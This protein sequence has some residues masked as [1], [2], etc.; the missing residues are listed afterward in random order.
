MYMEFAKSSLPPCSLPN[1]PQVST[2]LSSCA[3]YLERKPRGPWQTRMGW[4]WAGEEVLMDWLEF[5]NRNILGGKYSSRLCCFSS[6]W[7]LRGGKV[8]LL[9][10]TQFYFCSLD[11]THL[12]NKSLQVVF[13]LL[14]AVMVARIRCLKERQTSRCSLAS[15]GEYRAPL[16]PPLVNLATR[17]S[18]RTLRF[19]GGCCPDSKATTRYTEPCQLLRQKTWKYEGPVSFHVSEPWIA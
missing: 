11:K 9:V 19:G 12:P 3:Q 10:E 7:A 17:W 1:V 2:E 6:Q 15:T 8:Q 4:E 16:P 14:L 18:P 13:S 5:S